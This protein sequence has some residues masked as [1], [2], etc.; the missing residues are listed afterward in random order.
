M[1][2]CRQT[3]LATVHKGGKTITREFIDKA[4]K[5]RW[6]NV[7]KSPGDDTATIENIFGALD[8]L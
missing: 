2:R 7:E 4:G 3:Y 5:V 1:F 8:A 6:S